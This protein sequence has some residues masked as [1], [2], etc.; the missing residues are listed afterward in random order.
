ML[1]LPSFWRALLGAAF[2]AAVPALA[3]DSGALLDVLV[4]K[5][6]LTAQ[7][8]ENVR[9]ELARDS[10]AAV[11]GSVSG[12]KSTHSVALSGRLQLQYAGLSTDQQLPAVNQF[13]L[14]RVYLG[15]RAGVGPSWTADF[16]YDF[17]GGNFDKAFM[18][19]SGYVGDAPLTLD[20]GLRKVNLGYEEYTSS[21]SLKAIERSPVTRYFAE[22]NN[23]RRLGAASYRI[24]AF[25]EGGSLDA[26]K[27]KSEGFFYGAAITNPQ[28][29][30]TTL[31][32][33]FDGAKFSSGTNYQNFNHPAFWANLGYTGLL[34][35]GRYQFGAAAGSLPDQGGPGSANL[36]KGYDLTVYSVFGDLT[37]GRFNLAGEYLAGEVDAG[38]NT[39]RDAR[40]AGYWVQPS[41]LFTEKIEGV[42]RY[43]SVDADGRG[44]RASDGVRSAPAVRTG[45]RLEELYLGFNYYFVNQDVKLQVG[46]VQGKTSD[47]ASEKVSGVRSQLQVNF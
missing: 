29:T 44:I 35:G 17:A 2:F 6:V 43:S 36:G 14:R 42:A 22:P 19:W 20:F 9:A 1:K 5:G 32:A 27:G 34:S 39:I 16:N 40:P 46:Y 10:A 11:V 21:G 25:L 33:T 30:E 37:L 28:R 13:F 45:Q 18:E 4:R 7:E 24:G 3:Q 8:A 15:V 47:G 12:G 38:V 31:D 41:F 23:G 26:R